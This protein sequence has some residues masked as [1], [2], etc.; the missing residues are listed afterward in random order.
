MIKC[1][2]WPKLREEIKAHKKANVLLGG[3]GS[4]LLTEYIAVQPKPLVGSLC[5]RSL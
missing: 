4:R 3:G 1:Y 5:N 2:S